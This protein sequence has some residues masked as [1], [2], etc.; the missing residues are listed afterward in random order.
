M[1]LAVYVP[2]SILSER[3]G[4]LSKTEKVGLVARAA[5]IF[6][7][8]ELN[9]YHDDMHGKHEDLELFASILNYLLIPPYLRKAAVPIKDE[10]KY[11]GF[12]PPLNIPSHV[13][14]KEDEIRFG[15][16]IEKNGK[17]YVETGLERPVELRSREKI[18]KGMIVSIK[19]I[20]ERGKLY[21]IKHPYNDY[22]GFKVGKLYNIKQALDKASSQNGIIIFTSREGNP[23]SREWEWLKGSLKNIRRVDVF[24]GSPKRGLEEMLNDEQKRLGVWLNMIEGQKVK[25][26]RTEE[27]MYI[28][29]GQINTLIRQAGPENLQGK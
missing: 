7:V 3:A 23:I 29:L 13:I 20:R 8:D 19:L 12:L 25:T 9:I 14:S 16:V 5:A 21:A 4:L 18:E 2:D 27:A 17:F 26:V 10:F 24:F 11:V 6:G 28:C 1:K 15:Y 22:S